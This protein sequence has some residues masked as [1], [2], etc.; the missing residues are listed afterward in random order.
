MDQ[1]H[2]I[3]RLM[4]RRPKRRASGGAG[5]APAT[6]KPHR[7][8]TSQTVYLR[9]L[10]DQLPKALLKHHLYVL[11]S[12]YGEVAEIVAL[13]TPKMRGQAHVVFRDQAGA[14]LAL[15]NLQDKVFFGKPIVA[16]YAKETS[17][18]A[19]APRT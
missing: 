11:C 2:L 8:H 3:S 1:T 6:K 10:D 17:H 16:A 13:K 7:E 14:L 4:P 9:N 19:P 18:R 12:T 5:A 15:R